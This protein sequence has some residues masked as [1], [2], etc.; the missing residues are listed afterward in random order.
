MH[1]DASK[2]AVGAVL[3]QRSDDGIE[4]PISFFSK[5]LLSPQQNYSTFERECLVIVVA[6]TL[7]RV[8]LLARPFVLLT[9]HKSL[10][11]LLST[12]PTAIA[13]I[14][15]WIATVLEYPIVV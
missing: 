12:E 7:S 2:F 1:T 6:V 5:K 15:S 10:T 9:N 4:H 3:L 14:S 11:L 8:Y 13:R